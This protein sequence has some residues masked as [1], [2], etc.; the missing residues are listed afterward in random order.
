MMKILVYRNSRDILFEGM[1]NALASTKYTIGYSSGDIKQN[2]LQNYNPDII[3]HN[4]PDVAHFPLNN[5]SIS[6]GINEL[7]DEKCFSFKNTSSENYLAPFVYITP[8]E[9]ENYNKEKYSS[10]VVYI[11]SAGDIGGEVLAYLTEINNDIK[12]KF[13]STVPHNINGYCGACPLSDYFRL[14]NNAKACIVLDGL[15]NNRLMDIIIS[16]GNPIVI[17]PLKQQDSIEKIKDAVYNNKKFISEKF[18]RDDII[19]NHT[20][21]D[22]VAKIFN[23]IGLKKVAQEVLKQKNGIWKK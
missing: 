15:N 20:S 3:I 16:N 9:H 6:V 12:F 19:N 17:D 22:R 5:N 1:I 11:G 18:S 13:F 14:Y 7:D 8:E 10:D 4:I 23:T 21:F 2:D